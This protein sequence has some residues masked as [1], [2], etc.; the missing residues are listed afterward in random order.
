MT[1][2]L[3]Y[4]TLGVILVVSVLVV[5]FIIVWIYIGRPPN[6]N[7]KRY[8]K[9]HMK[10][11]SG[12]DLEKKVIVFIGDSIT[13]GKVCENYT[14]IVSDRLDPDSYRMINAGIHG[15]LTINALDRIKYIIQ[16]KP[17]FATVLLGTNDANGSISVR[18]AK[19]Y[20]KI[21]GVPKNP[22]FWKETRFKEDL[23]KI[24]LELK[25]KTKAKIAVIS[26]PPLGEKPETIPFERAVSYS[27]V[28]EEVAKEHNVSYLPL[29]ETMV[30][31][32][33]QNP[34]ES[35]IPF[36]KN[37]IIT[38]KA[39]YRHYILRKSWGRISKDNGFQLLTDHIHP[40]PIGAAM[41]A[42]L[43]EEFILGSLN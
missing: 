24:I 17:D 41:I 6:N 22:Q 7:P 10:K 32:L 35:S 26:I 21:K 2:I 19:Q 15:D 31:Y 37:E 11:K 34:T 42:D 4:V 14:S 30:T 29:N 16:C 20:E 25:Q 1:Y 3:F 12:D 23:G 27:N 28:I 39:V 5:L 18:T 43:I 33:K 40:N 36:E 38:I 13:L 8:L 9:D